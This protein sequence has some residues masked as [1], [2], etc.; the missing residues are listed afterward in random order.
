MKI[1]VH[2]VYENVT[3][4]WAKK[5]AHECLPQDPRNVRD[6]LEGELIEY[7]SKDPDGPTFGVTCWEYT[8]DNVDWLI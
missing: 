1:I 4:E 8:E 2:T 6:F 3:E 7:H 5:Y